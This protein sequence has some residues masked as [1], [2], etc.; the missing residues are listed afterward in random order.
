MSMNNVSDKLKTVIRKSGISMYRLE[1]DTGVDRMCI[2]RF[3]D[4]KAILSHNFDALCQYF[5]M[6]LT[7][8]T[9]PTS[10]QT[11]EGK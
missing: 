3:L 2:T 1:I 4:G 8:P 6:E 11:R 9:A 10:K 5:G 7:D